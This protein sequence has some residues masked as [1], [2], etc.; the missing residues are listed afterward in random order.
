MYGRLLP[1]SVLALAVGLLPAFA[2]A[3]ELSQQE[4]RQSVAAGKSLS[5][6]QILG[7]VAR[8]VP[9]DTV[10]VRA[11]DMGGIYFQVLVMQPNGQLA[12]VIVDA[13]TGRIAANGS[14]LAKAVRSAAKA[15]A[16]AASAQSGKSKGASGSKGNGKG[17]GGG[18]GNG[19]SGGGNGGGNGGN[20]NGGGKGNK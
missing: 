15:N 16:G 19:N 10:D 4:L 6:Q 7:S 12:S 9:G 5:L 18:N 2:A 17:G 3:H 13:A 14:P 1:V 20:G 11:F 8:S